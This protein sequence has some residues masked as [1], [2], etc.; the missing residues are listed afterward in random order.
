MVLQATEGAY[1]R[2]LS[3]DVVC[4]ELGHQWFGNYVTC[5]DFDNISGMEACCV[6]LCFAVSAYACND[7]SKSSAVLLPLHATSSVA[8][9]LHCKL[10]SYIA[11]HVVNAQQ[12]LLPVTVQ[13][14]LGCC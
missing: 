3:A 4:H 8:E 11:L 12:R 5:E 6:M 9:A 7:R 10:A 13:W 1:G 14:C 2:W